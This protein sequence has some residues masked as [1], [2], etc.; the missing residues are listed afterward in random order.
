MPIDDKL[1][2]TSFSFMYTNHE[3]KTSVRYVIPTGVPFYGETEWHSGPLLQWL[4]PAFDVENGKQRIFAMKDMILNAES[5]LHIKNKE[6]EDRLARYEKQYDELWS[7]TLP[8]ARNEVQ[9]SDVLT[10][11]HEL[12]T[13]FFYTWGAGKSARWA[14]LTDGAEFKPSN[15][16]AKIEELLNKESG[17]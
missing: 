13:V 3:G 2:E 15:A 1:K 16:L 4:M 6:L 14:Q 5:N 17:K 11:I 9:C 7:K 8:L 10:K 12:L